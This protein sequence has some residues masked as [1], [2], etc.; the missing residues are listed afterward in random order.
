MEENFDA[1]LEALRDEGLPIPID[2]F[3]SV[4]DLDASQLERFLETW[5]SL[6]A[7]RRHLLIALLGQQADEKFE[8]DF[9][10]INQALVDDPDPDVRRIAISNLWEF[11]DAA[12]IPPFSVAL[13]DSA[14]LPVQIAAA[15]A[16]GR[17]VLL[18]Q[19]GK[20]PEGTLAAIEEH[21]LSSLKQDPAEGLHGTIVELLGYSSREEASEAIEAAYQSGRE[22]LVTS[23]VIAMG[24]SY[25]ERWVDTIME[26]LSNSSPDIRAEAARAAG[27]L[28]IRRARTT[29]IELLDDVHDLVQR[30]AVWALGQIGGETALE[31]LSGLLE[32]TQAEDAL[33]QAIEDSLDHIAFLQGT[34]DF[35]LFD[36]DE[37]DA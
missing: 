26:E 19:L 6:S 20:L 24:R 30:N 31:A 16:L 13:Q 1:F 22:S 3:E 12:L 37:E 21:L 7:E 29:L 5:D 17:F 28:E 8:L 9:D 33:Y 23:A 32:A 2:E 25:H 34:P 11:E 10:R 35:L 14:H 18:G 15:E 4:S 27:E 36:L